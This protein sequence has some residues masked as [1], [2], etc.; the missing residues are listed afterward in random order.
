M[1]GNTDTFSS[2]LLSGQL[3][4]QFDRLTPC[5]FVQPDV[6]F[7]MA[8]DMMVPA[9]PQDVTFTAGRMDTP[10]GGAGL[11]PLLEDTGDPVS[12]AAPYMVGIFTLLVATN[13]ITSVFQP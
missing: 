5:L 7:K 1:L 2:N 3:T 12:V 11:P 13:D 8:H 10:S 9:E 6:P 4:F